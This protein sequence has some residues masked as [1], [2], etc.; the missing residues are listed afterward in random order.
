[1]NQ[2]TD[3]IFVSIDYPLC[4]HFCINLFFL[5]KPPS[6]MITFEQV[7]LCQNVTSMNNRICAARPPLS[8]PWANGKDALLPGPILS[9][10]TKEKNSQKLHVKGKENFQIIPLIYIFCHLCVCQ[11]KARISSL[12]YKY[13][14]FIFLKLR[15]TIKLLGPL[16]IVL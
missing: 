11:Y 2:N 9:L 13:Y 3:S 14:Y 1:M 16:N 4:H 7:H 5:Q 15:T 12:L 6:K 8:S 10:K